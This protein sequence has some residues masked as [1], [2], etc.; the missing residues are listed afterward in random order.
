ME[1]MSEE[2]IQQLR[3]FLFEKTHLFAHE[4]LSFA[5]SPFDMATYDE[6]AHYECPRVNVNEDSSETPFIANTSTTGN[7]NCLEVFF[8]VFH[9]LLAAKM[10]IM[11]YDTNCFV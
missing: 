7:S 10:G 1:I 6:R 8:K 4:F 9:S 11:A 3:P 2:F 5:R